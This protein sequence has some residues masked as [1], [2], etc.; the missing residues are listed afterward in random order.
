MRRIFNTGLFASIVVLLSSFPN[1]AA[2]TTLIPMEDFFKNPPQAN[3]QIS[4]DGKYVSF[5]KPFERRMNI[6]VQAVGTEDVSRVTSVTDRDIPVYWWKGDNRLLYIQDSGGDEKFHLFG[7]NPDGSDL[8]DLTP[9]EGVSVEIVDE[10]PDH[11]TDI[12]LSMNKTN[13]EVFD[14]YRLNTVTGELTLVAENLGDISYWM[15]DHD[16]NIRIAVRIDG[17]NR[18]YLFRD[19]SEGEFK[20]VGTFGFQD[21]FQPIL[22]TFDNKYLY[23]R[24]NLGRDR[25]AIVK[26]DLANN[27]ELELLYEHQEYDVSELKYSRKRKVLTESGYVDW[28]RQRKVFDSEVEKYY[29]I[30]E[31]RFPGYETNLMSNNRD[32]DVF[33]VQTL[34]DRTAG[35]FYLFD[36]KTG[37]I[38]KLADMN[39]W[40]PE[41]QLAEM[42]P[43]SYKS[44]DGLTIHGYLTAPRG[45]ES[46]NLPIVVCPHGGPWTRD[47]WRFRKDVQFLANRGFAVFQMN[48]RGSTGYGKAFVKAADK[49]W[50]KKMQDDISDG[51]KWL[52]NEGIADPERIAI[53]GKSYGGYATLAGLAFTPDLYA[54]GVDYVGISSLFTFMNSMPPHWNMYRQMFYKMIGDPVK[55]S[56]LMAE[57]SPLFHVDNIKVPVL[58]AQ[59]ANDPRVNINESNQ[60]VEA[61]RARGIEVVYMV[62]DNEGHGFRNEENVFDFYRAMEEFLTRHLLTKE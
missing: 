7:I 49:E 35:S 13:P 27:V 38:T 21:T 16:Y 9:Y 53:Y 36:T 2:E 52:I 46:K 62:K 23:A 20:E 31:E 4:P 57:A 8:A 42:K 34:S 33:I 58:V 41:D 44:R 39:P 37:G 10:M 14:V 19:S 32:E 45:V 56:L 11:E 3:F 22:F 26:H 48:F 28:K 50:G 40:L 43:I 12:L 29:K 15:T 25:I 51:V 17:L 55:D 54:C 30:L 47:S 1:V 24:S 60:I 18:I 5:T 61:L 6:F 59:G